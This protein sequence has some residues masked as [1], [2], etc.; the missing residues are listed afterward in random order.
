MVFNSTKWFREQQ[1]PGI[2]PIV[3]L[4]ALTSIAWLKKPAAAA[5]LKLHEL[6]ALCGAALRP[7]RRTWDRFVGY[8]RAATADG[9]LSTDG[10]ASRSW[11]G[12]LR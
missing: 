11:S 7:H 10:G 1:E 9:T 2:P 6:I 8:L 12:P 4:A 3:H 5:D